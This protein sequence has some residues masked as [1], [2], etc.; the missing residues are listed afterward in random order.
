V[1][2][3]QQQEIKEDN[4]ENDWHPDDLWSE[5]DLKEEHEFVPDGYVIPEVQQ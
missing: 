1:G 4:L 2:E 5:G 3:G